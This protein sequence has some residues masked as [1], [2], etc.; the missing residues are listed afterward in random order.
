MLK[1]LLRS[2]CM[3]RLKKLKVTESNVTLSNVHDIG[4]EKEKGEG[5][6]GIPHK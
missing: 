4:R 3:E 1:R 2:Q 5:N 6:T